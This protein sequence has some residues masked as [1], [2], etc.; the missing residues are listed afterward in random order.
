MRHSVSSRCWS[1]DSIV[2]TFAS[3]FESAATYA[4]NVVKALITRVVYS[5]MSFS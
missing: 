3:S 4:L 2:N 5:R 1:R